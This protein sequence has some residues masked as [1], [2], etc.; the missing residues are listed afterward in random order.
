MKISI[1]Y[2][3]FFLTALTLSLDLWARAGGGSSGGGAGGR[4]GGILNLTLLPFVLGYILW[5]N[6]RINQKRKKVSEALKQMASNEPQWNEESLTQT[7]RELFTKC[8]EAW[9]EQDL[10]ALKKMLH[11]NLYP[12]WKLDLEE[13]KKRLRRNR[14]RH[15]SINQIRIINIQNFANDEKDNFTVCFDAQGDDE[16]LEDET[17]VNVNRDSFREFWTFKWHQEKWTLL[18]VTQA[19]GWRRFFSSHIIYERAGKK[20]A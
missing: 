9:G 14:M 15:L 2:L 10:M 7:A 18:E 16:F 19:N 12:S 4:G 5:V 3:P 8:Q 11:P 1:R 17:I 6:I 13:Q 20:A